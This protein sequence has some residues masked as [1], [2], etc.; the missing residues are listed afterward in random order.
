M[1]VAA[2]VVLVGGGHAAAAFVNALRRAGFEGRLS[3]LSEEPV[4]PYHRPPL[5]RSASSSWWTPS[6]PRSSATATPS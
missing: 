2:H 1:D 5:S 6:S 4:L 3:L